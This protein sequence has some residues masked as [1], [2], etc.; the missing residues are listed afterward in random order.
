M[1]SLALPVHPF[2]ARMAPELALRRLPR[3]RG[4]S[5]VVLDPMMGSGTIPVLAS[6]H[7][8]QAIG[9]DKDPLAVLIAQTNG[10][11]LRV[12][13]YIRAAEQVAEWARASRHRPYIHSDPE[14]QE[15]IDYW[16][17]PETQRHLGALATHIVQAAPIFRRPLWCAFSRL[18]ITKDAGA[19]RARDVSH[20]RPHRVRE[21]AS[22][23]PIE[24]FVDAAQAV[25]RRHQALSE[26][27]VR[28]KELLL[29]RGDARRLSLPHDSVDAVITS[30][31]YLQAIDYMR[32][33][34]LSLIWMGYTVRSL[35][36]VRTDSIGSERGDDVE[37]QYAAILDSVC[38][39]ALDTRGGRI[40]S[41]Y[42]N[43]FGSVLSEIRR[44]L[45]PGGYMT[46]VV[47]D[48]T[49]RSA[50]VSVSSIVDG[51]ADAQGMVCIDR[52][53]RPIPSGSRYLPPPTDGDN[54][55]DRRMRT[56][57]CLTYRKRKSSGGRVRSVSA[58]SSSALS[59]GAKA[60]R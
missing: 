52:L 46:V 17:D 10:R 33:H 5:K 30:P 39:S 49:V 21:R 13:A 7:G 42:I 4:R 11:S 59:G 19:S 1:T 2:P 53:E 32:G 18:I 22:F 27:R 43:D 24:Q 44:V 12:P 56:E 28:A 58:E 3:T 29:R 15:F 23:D 26:R 38:P 25:G 8:Y 48:A 57:H 60:G 51:L 6:L 50:T 54:S 36:K 31:P 40:V 9:F 16:F 20:S 35:R 47:A 34:R 14:S 41:R 37:P 55:L 45:R